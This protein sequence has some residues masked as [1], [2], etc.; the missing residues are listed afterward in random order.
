MSKENHQQPHAPPTVGQGAANSTD[1]NVAPGQDIVHFTGN[2]IAKSSSGKK[3]AG[4]AGKASATEV[5][6]TA[7]DGIKGSGRYIMEKSGEKIHAM[8]SQ[9]EQNNA[10]L[11]AAHKAERIGERSIKYGAQKG[12]K[13]AGDR[14]EKVAASRKKKKPQDANGKPA[15]NP[16]AARQAGAAV[17]AA[18]LA[19]SSDPAM[20]AQSDAAGKSKLHHG[21]AP[22]PH[23]SKSTLKDIWETSATQFG[24]SVDFGST[25]PGLA[26]KTLNFGRNAGARGLQ[27]GASKAAMQLHSKIDQSA[28]DNSAVR[29][30]HHAEQF[31]EQPAKYAL[32]KGTRLAVV[33]VRK[34]SNISRSAARHK[35]LVMKKA[36]LAKRQ[37]IAQ[38]RGTV[39][40]S[41]VLVRAMIRNSKPMMTGLSILLLI[42]FISNMV[43]GTMVVAFTH[44]G[45]QYLIITTYP[46]S[47]QDITSSTA[48]W[49]ELEVALEQRIENIES[50]F[51]GFNEYRFNISPMKHCPFELISYL[52]AMHLEFTHSE[53]QAEILELFNEVNA[54]QIVE[55]AEIRTRTVINPDGSTGEEE[56]EWRIL[57]II[58]TPRSFSEVVTPRLEAEGAKDLFMIF[59]SSGGNQQAFGNPL[60]FNWTNNITSHFGMRRNP[61]G[62]GFEFHTGI[63]IAAPAGTPIRSVQDGFVVVAE[64]HHLFGYYIV[65]RNAAGISSLYAHCSVLHVSVSDEVRR[66][67]IIAAVGSTGNSTGPHLHFELMIG[68]ERVDPVFFIANSIEN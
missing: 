20:P 28:G 17:N 23:V 43:I 21:T 53:V 29:A 66:G 58:L 61:T 38:A 68:S 48:Q 36:F 26:T 5:K 34:L 52:A 30:A 19:A 49:R 27:F 64:Y 42:Y 32:K 12:A 22:H 59:M 65:I 62:P 8:V 39:M 45:A 57:N 25:K 31:A 15:A 6:D 3:V 46:V 50:E 67:Q 4:A 14:L 24:S 47:H 54:L 18:S 11:E 63:D 35:Y 55:E 40:K 13:I 1:S 7:T 16:S 10:A 56:Y 9:A 33:P 2:K 60:P 37:R 44:A 41:K 51:P